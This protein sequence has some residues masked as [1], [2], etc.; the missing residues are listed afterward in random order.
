MKDVKLSED[1]WKRLMQMKLLHN[2]KTVD[3]AVSM[4]F[5]EF[6][7]VAARAMVTEK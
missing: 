3:E 1:N 7:Q 4:L 2:F 5:E 6:D